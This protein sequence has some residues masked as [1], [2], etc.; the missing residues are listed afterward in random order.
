MIV[1]S[2]AIMS[3]DFIFML[4][5]HDVTVPNALELFER[6][7]GTGLRCVG[8]KDIGLEINALRRLFS[9][10]KNA[11]MKTFL[12]VVTMKEEE[13]FEGVNKAIEIGSHYLIGGMPQHTEKT[14]RYL[15]ERKSGT[16]FF[17]YIGKIVGHPCLLRGTIQEIVADAKRTR[18]LGADGI[19]LLAYRYDGDVLQ[20]IEAVQAATDLPLV[21]AGNVDSY[22]RIKE[23]KKLGVWAYTIGGAIMEKR[24]IPGKDEV[25]QI[26]A[27]L[28]EMN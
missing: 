20:L 22:E 21:I 16:K 15:K 5:H 17:P 26:K 7:K 10:M 12:E 14:I 25:E 19:N 23:M 13:H 3:T 11:R 28:R 9:E 8:C 1:V 27:V 6:V 24:F 18:K 2:R 4:T